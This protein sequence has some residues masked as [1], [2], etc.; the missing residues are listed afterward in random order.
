MPKHEVNKLATN[1]NDARDHKDAP[2]IRNK[3]LVHGLIIVN[4]A[5]WVSG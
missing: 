4:A 2:E 3:L 5:R 1:H